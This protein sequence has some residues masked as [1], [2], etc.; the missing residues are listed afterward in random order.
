MIQGYTELKIKRLILKAA[1]YNELAHSIDDY[2]DHYKRRKYFNLKQAAYSKALTI[3]KG[4]RHS[5]IKYKEFYCDD[6]N[7]HPSKLIYF[8]WH[9]QTK[10]IQFSFHFLL[11]I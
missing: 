8:E 11:L 10:F 6:Q 2:Y 5:T 7:G 9:E 1:I 4:L 3:L